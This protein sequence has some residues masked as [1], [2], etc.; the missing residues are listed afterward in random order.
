MQDVDEEIF[1]IEITDIA[2]ISKQP[3][4]GP[5]IQDMKCSQQRRT[6]SGLERSQWYSLARGSR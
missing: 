3:V 1:I 5:G 4:L 6:A 2:V